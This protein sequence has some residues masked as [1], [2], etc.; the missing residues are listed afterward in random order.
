MTEKTREPGITR[1]IVFD[2]V[3]FGDRPS[4][5]KKMVSNRV[6]LKPLVFHRVV[7]PTRLAELICHYGGVYVCML[8]KARN[9]KFLF[10]IFFPSLRIS[11]LLLCTQKDF[12]TF[13]PA[14]VVAL[15]AR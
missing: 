1:E 9:Q 15:P 11:P 12:A 10:F 3:G 13:P 6:V 2:R 4:G 8:L 7:I 14:R 5:P